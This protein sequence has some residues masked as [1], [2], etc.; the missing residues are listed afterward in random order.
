VTRTL[1][2]GVVAFVATALILA[3]HAGLLFA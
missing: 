2:P 3:T 1:L